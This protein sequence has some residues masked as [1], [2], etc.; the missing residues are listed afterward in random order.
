[1]ANLKEVRD[2]IQSVKNTQQ[3]TKAMKMVAASKLRRA[4]DAIV[5][6]RPYANKLNEMLRN[7][8]S[9]LEGGA[10]TS[11]GEERPVEKACVVV[12]TSSKGLCGAFN[13]N[14]IKQAIAIINGQYADVRAKGNLTILCVGKKG[15]EFFK[16]A[17]YADCQLID[18]YVELFNDLSFDNVSTVSKRLMQS[19]ERGIFDSV[20]VAYGQFKNAA[21]QIPMAD[22]FLPVAK[23]EK[24]EGASKH[25]ADYIFEPNK[26]ELLEHL[27]PS[28]IQTQFQKYVLDTHAS[29]HGARMTAMEAASENAQELIGELQLSY[30][31]ARQEAITNEILEIVG[32][33][34]ALGA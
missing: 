25:K 34:A 30:N 10:N 23:L 16:K 28:I 32:G 20:T 6:M 22:Q 24:E 11:F 33:A 19:F 4:Q 13:S 1:M 5:Q 15:Y 29:E 3:I 7:I 31:K 8:L 14:I 18:D 9:N 12:V 26:E 21:V 2:R 17:P 27:V